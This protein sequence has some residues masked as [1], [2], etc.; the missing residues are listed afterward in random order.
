[1]NIHSAVLMFLCK[2]I[3]GQILTGTLRGQNT[4][5]NWPHLNYTN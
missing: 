3:K 5:K 2:E 1:M 4:P